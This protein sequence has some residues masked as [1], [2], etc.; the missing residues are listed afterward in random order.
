MKLTLPLV[1]L[2]TLPPLA[3]ATIAQD[4]VKLMGSVDTDKAADSVDTAKM[5]RK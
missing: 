2:A 1:A 4:M 5:M 3:S